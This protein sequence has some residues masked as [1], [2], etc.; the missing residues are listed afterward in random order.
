MARG[1]LGAAVVSIELDFS[2]RDW[3]VICGAAYGA[4]LYD[5]DPRPFRRLALKYFIDSDLT[6]SSGT[7]LS[8]REERLLVLRALQ[9]RSPEVVAE[10]LGYESRRQ[11]LRALGDVYATLVDSYGDKGARAERE[12]YVG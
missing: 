11:C 6:D 4:G 5:A 8:A 1:A 12:R 2:A 10:I 3:R 9:A 7:K